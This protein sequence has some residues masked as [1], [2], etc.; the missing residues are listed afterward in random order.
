MKIDALDTLRI[1]RVNNVMDSIYDASAEL[2]ESLMDE[3][4]DELHK[5]IMRMREVLDNLEESIKDEL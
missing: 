2:Y 1:V 4:Y 3:E 5:N